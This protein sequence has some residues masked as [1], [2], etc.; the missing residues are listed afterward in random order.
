M[1]RLLSPS[2]GATLVSLAVGLA[3]F[4]ACMFL[5]DRKGSDRGLGYHSPDR[6]GPR[7]EITCAIFSSDMT[8]TGD[9]VRPRSRQASGRE[10]GLDRIGKAYRKGEYHQ[11]RIGVAAGREDRC[12]RDVKSVDA[13]NPAVLIDDAGAG[14][15]GHA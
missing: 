11:G 4:T 6:D 12:A 7:Y 8:P 2:T 5:I 14:S 3:V 13:V 10:L 15:F 1:L 9:R